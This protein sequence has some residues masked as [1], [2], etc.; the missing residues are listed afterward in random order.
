MTRSNQLFEQLKTRISV[1]KDKK[2]LERNYYEGL[3]NCLRLGS[4]D[5][6]RKL[7]NA[8]VD[9]N[10]FIDVKKIPN[11]FE[12]ISKLLLDCIERISTEYQ[13]S[14]LGEQIDILRFCNEFNIFEKEL[15]GVEIKSVEKIKNDNLFIANLIDLFGRV[16]DSFIS[17]VYLGL[18]RDLYNYFI[19]GSNEYFPDREG[20]MYY[21]KNNFFNQYTIYGLSVRYLSSKKQFIDTFKKCYHL[22]KSKENGEQINPSYKGKKFIEFNVIYRTIYYGGEEDHEYREIKKHLVS[23]QNIDKNLDNIMANDNYKFYSISMVLLGGLGPQGLGFTYS[24]PRGEIVEICSDQKEN[25]AIIIKFKQY[26]KRKF[27]A[28][29]ENE[30]ERL[31]VKTDIIESINSY[32]SEILNPEDL[33]SYNDMDSI[34]KKI[35]NLVDYEFQ[36]YKFELDEIMSKIS[37]V[38]SK[39]YSRKIKI[40]FKLFFKR[41]VLGRLEKEMANLDVD[42]DIRRRIK[43]FL[44]ESTSPKDFFKYYDDNSIS[45]AIGKLLSDEFQQ[46]NED[47]INKTSKAVSIILREI[48][49]KDQFM[50]RMDLVVEGK[51]KSED[52]AKLTSLKG[53]SHYDVLRERFFYQ[54]I[55]DWFYDVYIEEREKLS[56]KNSKVTF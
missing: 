38:F 54:Y 3:A 51:I 8:S 17:Y 11:R 45:E 48:K 20:L 53:K 32:L 56:K 37:K 43:N 26:L 31:G 15:T 46:L 28:K 25:E 5:S 41:R 42:V 1:S 9:F 12:L 33:V 39:I 2:S 35:K 47:I 24:T 27:L 14:A 34:L 4:F 44:L 22:P 50:T 36:Q 55:V 6:F 19:S 18:P 29:L 49:L 52:I 40:W 13:T 30:M 23:P 21:I 10:I 7:S 16:T